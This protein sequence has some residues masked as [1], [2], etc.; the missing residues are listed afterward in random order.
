MPWLY[1]I[2]GSSEP[3]QS[4]QCSCLLA[5]VSHYTVVSLP[6]VLRR[7][8][9]PV[10]PSTK[11]INAELDMYQELEVVGIVVKNQMVFDLGNKTVKG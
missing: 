8:S 2:E 10:V 3:Y 5:R 1:C 9:V 7:G 6:G 11:E 4:L